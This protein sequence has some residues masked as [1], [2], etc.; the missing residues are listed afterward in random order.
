MHIVSLFMCNLVV[1]Q[2]SS[3]HDPELL[4]YA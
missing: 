1:A 2:G 3:H 4:C